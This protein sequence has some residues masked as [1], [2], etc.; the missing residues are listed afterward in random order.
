MLNLSHLMLCD[1][2]QQVSKRPAIKK[3]W[4]EYYASKQDTISGICL[5]TGENTNIVSRK[6]PMMVKGVPGSS[7]SGAAI[8]SFDKAAYQSHGWEGNTNAPIGFESAVRFHKAL[9]ILMSRDANHKKIGRQA[10]VFWGDVEGEGI[11]PQLWEDPSAAQ[12]IFVTPNQ[13]SKLPSDRTLSRHFYLAA[14]KGN[15]G[16]IAVS[17]WDECTSEQIKSSV[18]RFVKCQQLTSDTKA[19]PVWVLRNSAFFDPVKEYTDKITTA[20]VKAALLGM[21]LPDEYAIRIMNRICQEQDV[22][23][24]LVRAQA[25]AFYLTTNVSMP[26]LPELEKRPTPEQVA[27]ILGRIAF[28]MH[29]AQVTAQNLQKEDTNVTRS[30]KALSTTPAQVFPRLYYGCIAHHLEEKEG[31]ALL[32]CIKKALDEEFAKFGSNFNP[33]IDLPDTLDVKAQACFFLGW[34]IRRAE[35]FT[36]SEE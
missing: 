8:T 11:D 12:G 15:K 32:F 10:F 16:R 24:S 33:S 31:G 4:G 6:M 36:K 21:P 28:L 3:W 13:P 18:K 25:L 30:L 17:S 1:Q 29:R 23:R 5:L 26:T 19:K 7:T 34:G 9:E 14:L 20:L 2:G 27:Y 35:F 22:M